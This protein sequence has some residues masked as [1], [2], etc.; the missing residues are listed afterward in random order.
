MIEV[1]RRKF[2]ILT[3]DGQVIIVRGWIHHPIYNMVF[4]ASENWDD[5]PSYERLYQASTWGRIRSLPRFGRTTFGVRLYGGQIIKPWLLSS[6]SRKGSVRRVCGLQVSLS[7]NNKVIGRS[8]H[9]LVMETF[10]GPR[11][12]EFPDCCHWDGDPLNNRLENLRW[13]THSNNEAD[14]ER[15]G[16]QTKEMRLEMCSRAGKKGAAARWSKKDKGDG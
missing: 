2:P 10:V 4:P 8:I 13:D 3:D 9:Q 15:H 16:T 5:I 1:R 14:K 12:G 6:R 11:I 7:K